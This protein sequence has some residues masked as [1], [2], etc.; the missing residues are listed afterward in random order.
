MKCECCGSNDATVLLKVAI[1]DQTIESRY[2]CRGCLGRR[3]EALAR[4]EGEAH[5]VIELDS[6]EAVSD[7]RCERCGLTF[8]DFCR[9]SRLG[10]AACYEVFE[11]HLVPVM[12]SL[13]GAEFWSTDFSGESG[14]EP[15]AGMRHQLG[16]LEDMLGEAIRGERYEVA[17]EIRN[18]IEFVKSALAEQ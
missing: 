15:L 12:E 2:L 10:C 4:G 3:A 18:E 14:P 13:H 5:D 9:T 7:V 1:N 16:R 17:A 11:S 8:S 6:P